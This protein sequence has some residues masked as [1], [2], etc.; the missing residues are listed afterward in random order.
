MT[1]LARWCFRHRRIVVGAWFALL[2]V[3]GGLAAS[4]GTDFR[5]SFSLPNTE[6]QR[7]INLLQREFPAQGGERDTIVVHTRSGTVRDAAVRAHVQAML[8]RVA[9]LPHVRSVASPYAAEGAAQISKDGTIAFAPVT[10]DQLVQDL[11][12]H[13]VRRV[14]DT[15]KAARSDQLQVELGG[16]AIQQLTQHGPQ[17]SEAI[18]IVA[19]AIILFV[20]F[21]SL[22]A[23]LLPL[24][25]TVLALG[26]ASSVTGLL[27]HPIAMADFSPQLAVLI[28]LGVGI[29][30]ALFI[31][32]RHRSGMK[33][34][35]APEESAMTALNTS[36]RAVLFAG[37]TV[38]IAMLG[39]LV[40][41]LG[42][43]NGA[44]IASTIAVAF[45]VLSAV[46][47]LPAM[48]GFLGPKVLNR[49]ERRRLAEE[50]P[51][52]DEL[53]G[54]WGRWATRVQ[55][56]P[57]ALA[58]VAVLVLLVLCIPFL[59]LRL[60]SSDQGNDAANTT[61]RK[62]Y[63][64]LAQGFG[65]GFNGPLQVAA[66]LRGPGDAQKLQ[67]FA[68]AVQRDPDVAAV[69]PART[70]PNGRAAIVNVY[71]RTS[72]QDKATSDLLNRLRDTVVPRAGGGLTVYVGGQT[73]IFDDFAHVIAGKLPL[74][75]GVVVLLAFILLMVAFRS[76]L[77][78]T[79]AAIMNL[80]AAGAA[81][82]VIV[83]VFQW[84][85]GGSLIGVDRSGPIESFLPVMLFAILFG[86]SM[87]YQVFLVSRMH[88]EWVHRRDNEQAITIGQARTGRVITSA[89]AIMVAVFL[90]FVVGGE[91]VIKEFGIGLAAAVLID[92]FVIRTVL[93]PSL[94]HLI[95]DPNWWL[96]RW[97]DR[98]LPR[99]SIEAE[100]EYEEVEA[101]EERPPVAAG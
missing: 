85:W 49:R 2:L 93:V 56:H 78:P 50:G 54:W 97:L 64:L 30:Y 13:D 62:A 10:F 69:S 5:N 29:D 20:A 52:G 22:A 57:L 8:D 94:M 90:S 21:G 44:A 70:S 18:G 91:R 76:V 41:G 14:V 81:F 26:V 63:D 87:D 82:G 65:P 45:T 89:A 37:A 4:A 47:L 36:G 19:A 99:V 23:M 86:L 42:F 9:K 61:T 40:L 34:G 28:G 33:R 79:T 1:S 95:G 80:L 72:P 88:E 27:S 11:S 24:I 67:A 51:A 100:E 60:G 98:V 68:Q 46:T 73:A 48:L 7:A 74:F 3:V 53:S 38:C 71:P 101:P 55:R 84:G 66:E 17:A 39:L 6:S 83:A 92:A 15:A 32:T 35:H 16:S 31:V 96:P 58:A 43:L 75:I 59:S 77:V 25:S 12:K